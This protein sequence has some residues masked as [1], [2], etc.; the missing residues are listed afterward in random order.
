L[1][2][3]ARYVSERSSKDVVAASAS[4]IVTGLPG[5]RGREGPRP[6]CGR[7]AGTRSGRV[8]PTRE[9]AQVLRTTGI[10]PIR[11]ALDIVER[12]EPDMADAYMRVPLEATS[13]CSAT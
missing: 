2:G 6:A 7:L 4:A 5:A 11:S 1:E 9:G 13:R 8:T 10:A 3:N 12:Q